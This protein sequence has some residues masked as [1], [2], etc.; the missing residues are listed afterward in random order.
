MIVT[1]ITYEF[2]AERILCVRVQKEFSD[3]ARSLAIGK[4]IRSAGFEKI[5]P[6]FLRAKAGMNVEPQCQGLVLSTEYRYSFGSGYL[7]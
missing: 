2:T 1:P 5:T 7:D 4:R 6:S 3:L